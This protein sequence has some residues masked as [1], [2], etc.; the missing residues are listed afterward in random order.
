MKLPK[1]PDP[2]D[3]PK[4]MWGRALAFTPVIMTVV[5]T[6]LAGLSS[7]EMTKAQYYRTLAAQMQSKAGDQWSF[8]QAK[9][10]RAATVRNT[11]EIIAAS[12]EAGPFD[13]SEMQIAAAS[14]AA[15]VARLD[16]AAK[17][18]LTAGAGDKE[19]VEQYLA[20]VAARTAKL[21]QIQADLAKALAAAPGEAEK[22]P[23]WRAKDAAVVAA[24][25]A[26]ESGMPESKILP[27]IHPVTD[28][29]IRAE[30]ESAAEFSRES[31]ARFKPGT[32]FFERLDGVVSAEQSV[33]VAAN[34]LARQPLGAATNPAAALA[35]QSFLSMRDGLQSDLRQLHAQLATARLATAA[36]RY[37]G[38]AKLNQSTAYLYEVQIRVEDAQSSRHQARSQ[39]FFFGMLAAQAAVVVASLALAAQ[40]RNLMWT[41]A[42]AV[43]LVAI[44]FGAYV[45]LF[46]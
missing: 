14:F 12:A 13:P 25:E 4:S 1:Q 16:A 8:F 23:A 24:A 33:L 46:V 6:L 37:D 26:V 39:R 11:L 45:Y 42:A 9:K 3:L 19:A 41:L 38:E 43:G 10:L 27:L 20:G 29:A 35:A 34:R 21:E 17:D 5:A 36:A 2:A 40:R 28:A 18:L 15:G 32:D 30:L 7:S 44:G 22:V 31:D